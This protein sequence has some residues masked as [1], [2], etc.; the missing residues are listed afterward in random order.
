MEN[1][2]RDF[3]IFYMNSVPLDVGNRESKLNCGRGLWEYNNFYWS[4]TTTCVLLWCE[5][6]WS[7]QVK[8]TTILKRRTIG[9]RA[10]Y[11]SNFLL[12][13]C[14]WN[15][16]FTSKIKSKLWNRRSV[17]CLAASAT[18]LSWAQRNDALGTSKWV[19]RSLGAS[20]TL[21][22]FLPC[23]QS[24]VLYLILLYFLYKHL[25]KHIS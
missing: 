2:R 14:Q 5:Y 10:R 11:D 18:P 6:V 8:P 20:Y 17:T 13:A 15:G 25:I 12:N 7:R 4:T 3:S 22:Q 19:S 23:C 21:A 9:A 1:T 16:A 24:L